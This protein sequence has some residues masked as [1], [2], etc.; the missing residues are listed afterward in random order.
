MNTHEVKT[1]DKIGCNW[2]DRRQRASLHGMLQGHIEDTSS[3][4]GVFS[5]RGCTLG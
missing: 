5:G 4:G 3:N 1:S 2:L